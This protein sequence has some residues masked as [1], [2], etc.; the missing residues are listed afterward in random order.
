MKWSPSDCS[1][2]DMVRVRIGSVYHYGIFVSDEE[3]IAFGMPPLPKYA[4][5]PNRFIVCSTDADVFCAGQIIEVGIMDRKE[6]K[7]RFPPEETVRRARARLGEDG[8]HLIRNNC[9]HFAYECV[10]GER[11]SLQEEAVFRM[12][13][14]RKVCNVYLMRSDSEYV[15]EYGSTANDTLPPER[16]DEVNACT[17]PELRR[18]RLADWALLRIAS[19]H[20]FSIDP[21]SLQFKKD[22]NG[23]WTC[24]RFFFSFSHADGSVCVAVSNA[25]VGV[26]METVTGIE[27]RFDGS[28]LQKLRKHA[29]SAEEQKHWPEGAEGFIA[30]W[31]RKEAMFKCSGKKTFRP[32]KY[33]SLTM[34][35]VTCEIK[36]ENRPVLSVC[37]QNAA[38]PHIYLTDGKQFRQAEWCDPGKVC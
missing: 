25:P 37:G 30:C 14:Q 24:D 15:S 22:K 1:P 35:G 8:Y 16:L 18:S 36:E 32:E 20:C 33:D 21:D 38:S 17:D 23:A 11:R 4:E 34:Q 2:G 5:D 29:F 6:R 13:D 28:A 31:T 3:V 9:E 27:R 26:D 10:F 7:K 19:K 12:W